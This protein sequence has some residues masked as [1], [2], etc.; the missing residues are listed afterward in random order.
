MTAEGVVEGAISKPRHQ[1]EVPG[2]PELPMMQTHSV[3]K[4]PGLP[5]PHS[6]GD[7]CNMIHATLLYW[8]VSADLLEALPPK[9]LARAGD[10][11]DAH[12]AVVVRRTALERRPDQA[13]I[14]ILSKLT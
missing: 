12:E 11:F 2:G 6:R 9:Q 8:H 4:G 5:T 3:C 14:G 13:Q 7:D 1:W 10:V